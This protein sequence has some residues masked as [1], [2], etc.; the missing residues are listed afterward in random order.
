[1]DKCGKHWTDVFVTHEEANERDDSYACDV[2]SVDLVPSWANNT[3]GI[4]FDA[5][6]VEKMTQW[7]L[8]LWTK[9]YM[10]AA[11]TD[12]ENRF[13]KTFHAIQVGDVI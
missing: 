9:Q 2:Q 7:V 12:V 8:P 1:M 4:G 5:V 3:F 11:S 6:V 10:E 13:Y